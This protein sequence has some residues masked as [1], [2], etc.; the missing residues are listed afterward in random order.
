MRTTLNISLPED[1]REWVDQQ[2]K[3]GGYATVSEFFRELVRE[4]RRRKVKAEIDA[5]LLAAMNSGDPIP[6]TP[7]FWQRAHEELERRIQTMNPRP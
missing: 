4:E 5:K 3:G 7:E 1:M 6:M 2:V